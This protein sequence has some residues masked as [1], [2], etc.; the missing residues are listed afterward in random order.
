M[1]DSLE[2]MLKKVNKEKLAELKKKAEKGELS[3]MLKQVDT[4]KA[5]QLLRKLGLSEQVKG[6]DIAKALEAVKQN[7]SIL[8]EL[9]KKL[10]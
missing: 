8:S 10:Q 6:A 1:S 2:Q 5:E 9:K 7:P 4:E 3:D